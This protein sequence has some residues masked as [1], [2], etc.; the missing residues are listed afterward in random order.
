MKSINSP[1]AAS[2]QAMLPFREARMRNVVQATIKRFR[3]PSRKAQSDHVSWFRNFEQL[4]LDLPLFDTSSTVF[5]AT[6]EVVIPQSAS[7]APAPRVEDV[8]G[9]FDDLCIE[10]IAKLHAGVL[11]RHLEQLFYAR[12]VESSTRREVLEWIYEPE[13]F[14][15]RRADG[16]WTSVRAVLVPFTFEACC[17]FEQIDAY[18]LRAAISRRIDEL[19]GSR[20]LL[21]RPKKVELQ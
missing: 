14:E 19:K 8:P 16:T 1:G 9:N 17:S 2:Q 11:Y 20:S 5:D 6:Y 3:S 7:S 12:D 18:Q 13:E 21:A 15:Q 4:E 10:H